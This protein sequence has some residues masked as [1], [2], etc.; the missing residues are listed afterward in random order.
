MSEL[1]EAEARMMRHALGL[2]RAKE[3]YRN[4]YSAHK[5]SV[6]DIMWRDL[7]HRGLAWRGAPGIGY[8]HYGVTPAGRRALAGEPP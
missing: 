4:S 7:F 3:A 1:T 5:N 6:E 2:D 8:N